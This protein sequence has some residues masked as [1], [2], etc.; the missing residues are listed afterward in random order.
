MY[1]VIEYLEIDGFKRSKECKKRYISAKD[2]EDDI[3]VLL[4]KGYIIY[5]YYTEEVE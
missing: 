5:A 3:L 1:Y 4:L 2:A